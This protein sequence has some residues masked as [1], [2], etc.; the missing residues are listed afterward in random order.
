[1]LLMKSVHP[2]LRFNGNCEEAFTFYSSVF[3]SEV[4]QIMR[5]N[6]LPGQYQMHGTEGNKVM[7][8]S[9]ML[10]ND[11]M[12]MGCDSP[13]STPG[14]IGD[15]FHILLSADSVEEADRLFQGLSGGGKVVMPMENAF[16]GSYFGML[17][18][19]FNNHWMISFDNLNEQQ[20]N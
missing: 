2:Y 13:D 14:I 19:K 16:W 17:T 9:I 15:N 8:I 12:L 18:D 6:D 11:T 3:N 5:Y 20:G 10:A 7:H 4:T 1:M